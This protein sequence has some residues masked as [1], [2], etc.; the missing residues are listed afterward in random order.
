MTNKPYKELYKNELDYSFS[1]WNIEYT[2]NSLNRY[3][4][5]RTVEVHEQSD[6]LGRSL[7]KHCKSIKTDSYYERSTIHENAIEF[8]LKYDASKVKMADLYEEPESFISL[9]VGS[10][11]K[12]TIFQPYCYIQNR[13]TEDSATVKVIKGLKVLQEISRTLDCSADCNNKLCSC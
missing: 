2:L 8:F 5:R 6:I 4:A 13:I 7:K 10:K 1:F 9:I 3:L 11:S 12:G